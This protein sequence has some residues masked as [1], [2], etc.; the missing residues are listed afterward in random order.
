[1]TA[2]QSELASLRDEIR[3]LRSEV[4]QLRAVLPAAR[5]WHYPTGGAADQGLGTY[6]VNATACPDMPPYQYQSSVAAGCA[7]VQIWGVLP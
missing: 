6:V 3:A 1:M 7:P 5:V 2:E 4:A